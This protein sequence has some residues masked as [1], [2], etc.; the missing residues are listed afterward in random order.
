MN[1]RGR[2]EVLILVPMR[3]A[4]LVAG[5]NLKNLSEL[6]L[7][8]RPSKK[9]KFALLDWKGNY[10]VGGKG[11]FEY[12]IPSGEGFIEKERENIFITSGTIPVFNWNIVLI[13]KYTDIFSPVLA[14]KRLTFFFLILGIAIAI[15]LSI[16]FSKKITEPI[17]ELMKGARILGSGNLSYRIKLK[18]GDELEKL[19]D[20][21]NKMAEELKKSYDLLDERVKMATRNLQEAYQEIEE[22]NRKLEEADKLKSQFLANMSH[23]LRTPLNAIIG[24]TDLIMSGIYGKVNNKQYEKLE[25]VKIN[26]E[27][28]LNLINDIL[29]LSKIEAGRMELFPERFKVNSLIEEIKSSV[30][31]LVQEKGLELRVNLFDE[32]E[33]NLDPRKFRQIILNL[34][35]NAIKFTKEGYVEISLKK[36]DGEFEVAVKDTGIGIKEE[37]LKHIFD[38]FRQVDGSTAREFGGTGLGLSISKKLTELMGGRIEVESKYGKGS[39][40]KIIFPIYS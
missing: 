37:D 22:K 36:R 17:Y 28:L 16:H 12:K 15:I 20:A 13:S 1:Y 6:L 19:A 34:V 3:K 4:V 25:R 27:H 18:T 39:T 10:I 9:S 29:D 5:I 40:F 11:E 14:L 35:S 26:A 23:E 8:I 30:E 33:A 31:G 38:E 2:N 32:I 24:F 7:K 21:F